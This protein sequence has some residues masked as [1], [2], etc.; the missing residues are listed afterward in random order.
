MPLIKKYI[1]IV[2]DI[3][4]PLPDVYVITLQAQ[5]GRFRYK[6]GQFIH[7]ALD[8]YDPSAQWPESRCFSIQTNPDEN[9]LKITYSVKGRF[10]QRMAGEL[11][12]G[13]KIWIKLP[14]GELFSSIRP[15]LPCV[16]IAGGTGVT[17]YLSLFTG[18]EFERFKTPVL[19]FGARSEEYNIYTKEFDKA[20]TINPSFKIYTRYEDAAGFLD[21]E[22]IMQKQSIG[23]NFYI[24]GPP[25]MIKSFRQYLIKIGMPEN[26]VY[27][28]EWK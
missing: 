22:H 27:T 16:F 4:H 17:P 13:K 19:Y 11:C 6:P 1:T 14:Y 21:I 28:D 24:S 3:E 12:I 18:G 2:Q 20:C 23:D 10:T 9:C 7:L 25:D 8:P 5:E 15:E 26:S